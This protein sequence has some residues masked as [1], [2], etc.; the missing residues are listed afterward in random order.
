MIYIV[1]NPP[2]DAVL[3]DTGENFNNEHHESLRETGKG[4]V[5]NELDELGNVTCTKRRDR[6]RD[7]ER[8]RVTIKELTD[9]TAII[10]IECLLPAVYCICMYV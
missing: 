6:E 8:E 9:K 2:V 7:R 3:T 10:W 1:C 4:V 5:L